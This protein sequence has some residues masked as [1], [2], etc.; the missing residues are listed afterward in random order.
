MNKLQKWIL[1][2]FVFAILITATAVVGMIELKNW[3]NRSEAMRAMEQLQ[4]AVTAYRQKNGFVPSESHVEELKR[5]FE[6]RSRA[7]GLNYRARW[8]S[9]DSSPDTILAYV[10]ENTHSLFFHPGA[11]VLRYN[12]RVEWIDK[13]S[14]DKLIAGQQTPLELEMMSK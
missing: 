3:V 2:N 10:R 14:F 6:G 11:I 5:T 13:T 9:V 7:G 1:T 8:I 12:G 4:K